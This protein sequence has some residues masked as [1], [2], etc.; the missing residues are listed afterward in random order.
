MV[1]A[2]GLA[3]GLAK[4]LVLVLLVLWLVVLVLL[5]VSIHIDLS[6]LA[7][8]R[9]HKEYT[10]KSRNNFDNL[11]DTNHN[12]LKPSFLLILLDTYTPRFHQEAGIPV[13]V[14]SLYILP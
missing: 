11:K 13:P 5:L 2:K 14:Y 8:I 12:P 10:Q 4:G 9:Y 1:L 7:G 3:R 6:Y